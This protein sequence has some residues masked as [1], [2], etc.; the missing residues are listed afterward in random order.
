MNMDP[1]GNCSRAACVCPKCPKNPPMIGTLV[2][3]P[4]GDSYKGVWCK[5]LSCPQCSFFWQCRLRKGRL[6]NSKIL[7]KHYN[8]NH[9]PNF[10]GKTYK[11]KKMAREA[12]YF[13]MQKKTDAPKQSSPN[14]K[15]NKEWKEDRSIGECVYIDELEKEENQLMEEI[16]AES[17]DEVDFF[18]APGDDKRRRGI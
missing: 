17:A 6:S 5:T 18:G 7:H 3:S 10:D 15:F 2:T 9:I 4:K 1:L 12:D 16:L 11:E 13:Y 14:K 8:E